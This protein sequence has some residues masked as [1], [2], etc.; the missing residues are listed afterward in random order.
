[1]KTMVGIVIYQSIGLFFYAKL[2]FI[3]VTLHNLQKK[4]FSVCKVFLY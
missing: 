1:M 4:Q 3:K 2:F